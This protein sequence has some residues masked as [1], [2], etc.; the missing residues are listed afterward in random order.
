MRSV[1]AADQ[2]ELHLAELNSSGTWT[3][4]GRYLEVSAVDAVTDVASAAL[5]FGADDLQVQPVPLEEQIG[6]LY[7][8]L[9]AMGTGYSANDARAPE[10]V[11]T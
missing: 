11:I 9:K 6:T 8:R 7:A 1:D 2:F 10:E 4:E 3:R 5:A